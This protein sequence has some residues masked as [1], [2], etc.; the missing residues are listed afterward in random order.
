[1]KIREKIG[2]LLYP[3]PGDINTGEFGYKPNRLVRTLRLI[4]RLIIAALRLNSN[5]PLIVE[6]QQ[7]FD[8]TMKVSLP[9]GNSLILSTGHGR[10]I[11]R[12]KTL[13]TEEPDIIKWID[14]FE[15][16]D[17]FFDVGANVG[18]YSLYAAKTRGVKCYAFEPEINNLQILYANIYKNKLSRLCVALPLACDNQTKIRP[19][20]ISA[21]SK[22]IANNTVGRKSKFLGDDKDM[23]VQESLCMKIDDAIKYFKIPFPTKVKIDVDTNELNVIEG[24]INTLEYVREICVE[25]Y[26]PFQEHKKVLDILEQKGFSV[27]WV[28]KI[29]T[30]KGYEEYA[31]YLFKK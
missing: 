6:M 25:L 30:P 12:A 29:R 26:S 17:V 24:M 10:L 3:S 14:A 4:A 15:S 1:M 19:F 21:F 7:M 18:G 16:K 22:G 28:S 23:F 27:S 13:L 5:N 20:Y 8:P 9:D 31:N 11:W 2:K